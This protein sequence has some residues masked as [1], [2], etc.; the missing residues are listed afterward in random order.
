MK[1]GTR[2]NLRRLR[3]KVVAFV[4]V[5]TMALTSVAG[6]PTEVFAASGQA[7]SATLSPS[8]AVFTATLAGDGNSYVANGIT[9]DGK[10]VFSFDVSAGIFELTIAAEGCTSYTTSSFVLGTDK[11]PISIELCQGDIN[12]DGVINAKDNGLIASAF[13]KRK[14]NDGYNAIADFNKDG[15]INAKDKAIVSKN[16]SKRNTV[17]T[18]ELLSTS[19]TDHDGLLDIDEIDFGTD[20][21]K[22]DTDEDG[23]SD[24]TEIVLGTDP[25]VPDNYSETL[26]TDSDG[27][28][29][30][31]EVNGKYKTNPYASDTDDDGL[32][33]FEEI[34]KYKTDPT[35]PDTDG[36]GLSDGFEVK[37]GLD[38]T[39]SSTDGKKNDS[40]VKIEQTL[41]DSSISA[42]LKSETN[43]AK[44]VVSGKVSGELSKNVFL[45]TS[46]DSSIEDNRSIIGSAVTVD[47]AASYVDGLTLSFDLNDYEGDLSNLCIV[48][49][50]EDGNF[51]PISSK[52]SDHNLSG[53]ITKSGTY[54]VLNLDE[55]L[56]AMGIDL[57]DYYN[58]TKVKSAKVDTKTYS[59]D[60]NSHDANKIVVDNQAG[61]IAPVDESSDIMKQEGV[62]AE[63]SNSDVNGEEKSTNS[64]EKKT[65][66]PK[67]SYSDTSEVT[68]FAASVDQKQLVQLNNANAKLLSSTVSGQADIV[69]VIDTTGSMSSTINNV[70][71]NVT[72]FA[73]TLSDNYNVK[74]NYALIDFKDLEEDGPNTTLVVKNG[75]S[76]WYSNVNDFV[77][78]VNSLVAEGGGDA[79][80]CDIDALETARRLDFR[81]SA[82]KFVILITDNSYKIANSYGIESMEKEI[83]LL[84]DSGIVTSVVTTSSYK[85]TYQS[86][87]ETTRGIYA[88][89]SSSDFSSSLLQL[90]ELIGETTA[91]DE[92]VILKHGYRYVKI[93]DEND[94]DG[95][96]IST[97]AELGEKTEVNLSPIIEMQ[98]FIHKVPLSDY[99]GKTKITVYDAKSDPTKAD[100]DDDGILDNKDTAPWTKGL[101]DGVIGEIYLL[102]CHGDSIFKVIKTQ[103]TGHS[104]LVYKS[105][106]NDVWDLSSWNNGYVS[107]SGS[108]ENAT[109]QMN[110]TSAYSLSVNEAFTFSAGGITLDDAGCAV[111]NMEL[112]KHKNKDEEHEGHPYYYYNSYIDNYYIKSTVTQLQLD[113]MMNTMSLE[114]KEK[115]DLVFHN[116]THVSLNV[117]NN[118]YGTKINPIGLNSPRNLNVWLSKHDGIYGFNLDDVL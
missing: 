31:Q 89:I 83:S 50:D 82:N 10:T 66:A 61:T 69:F 41:E 115:Y 71:T 29:D 15:I 105:Y 57:S 1:K 3:M 42:S 106:V 58:T 23:L 21:N 60:G 85:S 44:P 8:D 27:L 25:L 103:S 64:A 22:P 87:Y 55:F 46:T 80:E 79:P 73:T 96:G 91:S 33:D 24:Y 70:V 67:K 77:T 59:N 2:N 88:N 94:Q 12:G 84:A 4:T 36:D 74:V 81:K 32:N 76:N 107:N 102:A 7:L 56:K 72:S 14:G 39:K 62:I 47:G 20:L 52:L 11:L 17:V 116:C 111:Y 9:K 110:P 18:K 101:K 43:I 65:V 35:N 38:P 112:F 68:S 118:M 113:K 99:S 78:K 100:T 51:E 40:D 49:L 104:F 26:D 5:F 75:S 98:L 30:I 13:G 53:T 86:L 117:W 109:R 16:F 97:K 108:W 34:N 63:V 28:S 92:W 93:T 95:D 6:I 114:A 19:D 48:E 37:N 45:A 90:A 54:L